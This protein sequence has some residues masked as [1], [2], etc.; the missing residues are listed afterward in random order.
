MF[1]M[2]ITFAQKVVYVRVD[3]TGTGTSWANASSLEQAMTLATSGDQ[4]WVQQGL[5]YPSATVQVPT[6]VQM[7]GGFLGNETLLSQRNYAENRTIIDGQ[8]RRVVRL[9]NNAVLDGFA[10]ING[11]AHIDF[12]GPRGG[13]VWMENNARVEN[14]YILDNTASEYGGGIHAV[15]DGLVYN[16]LF[17]GNIAGIDGLAIY[18][19]TLEVRNVTISQNSRLGDLATV[20][21]FYCNIATPA[22]IIVGR[23][24]FATDSIWLTDTLL[25][26]DAVTV[27]TCNK[28]FYNGGEVGPPS[29]FH[30][31]CRSNPDF[32]GDLFSWCAV[33][34]FGDELCPAPW[35]VPT[36]QDFID[37]DMTMG[38]NGGNNQNIG[39]A[40]VTARYL[41]TWGGAYGGYC[42]SGGTLDGQGLHAI[43]WSQSQFNTISGLRLHFSFY[44]YAS[45]QMLH[46][47]DFGFTLRCVYTCPRIILNLTSGE[48]TRTQAVCQNSPITPVTHSWSGGAATATLAWDVIPEGITGNA[49][50]F[51][52][53]PT[54]PGVYKWTIT[55][56]HS[57]SMCPPKI[58]TGSIIVKP[59]PTAIT[60]EQTGT[61][62]TCDSTILTAS[63]GN[64]GTIYWQNT[65]YNGTDTTNPSTSQIVY[66]TGT[67][68][69]R[70]RS[71]EGCWGGSMCRS[72]TIHTAPL[73]IR[74][75]DT[76]EQ[77]VLEGQSNFPVLSVSATS[78]LPP[79]LYQWYRNTTNSNIGGTL[80]PGATSAT[81]TPPNTPAGTFYY[82]CRVSNSCGSVTSNVSGKH[83]VEPL[84]IDANGC[85]NLPPGWGES[86]GV[87]SFAT[88]SIWVLG[89]QAWSDAIQTTVCNNKTN[90]NG[91]N[92]WPINFNADCRSSHNSSSLFS[93]CAVKR[94]SH[95]LCPAPWRVP[96]RQDFINLNETFGGSS[97]I[98]S[99]PLSKYINEWGG[100]FMGTCSGIGELSHLNRFGNYWSQT[101]NPGTQGASRLM[102]DNWNNGVDLHNSTTKDGGLAL[103]CVRD[104]TPPLPQ[105]VGIKVYQYVLP[106]NT[107]WNVSEGFR[108][109][110]VFR[111][112]NSQAGSPGALR[113][114]VLETIYLSLPHWNYSSVEVFASHVAFTGSVPYRLL[115]APQS[116]N[117]ENYTGSNIMNY[118]QNA[119]WFNRPFREFQN[120]SQF[121][122][123]LNLLAVNEDKINLWFFL[124]PYNNTTNSTMYLVNSPIIRLRINGVE[125]PTF[126][127]D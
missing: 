7:Y 87:V 95:V 103:R 70:A 1:A 35:R 126:R 111:F 39:N 79:P 66:H 29:T 114:N 85:N 76:T 20:D 117:P 72:V 19:T 92:I 47:K 90:F 115:T 73:I 93:W 14:C 59:S 88:D 23:Q 49:A 123:P 52:G 68:C 9:G 54:T 84:I 61:I 97:T 121:T 64:D 113:L 31:D 58:D 36:V 56:T 55:A 17:S 30:A 57:D 120:A 33:K 34:R 112:E 83:T 106:E 89:N 105:Q 94:F 116:F 28:P 24:S 2:F 99:A 125:I 25:W 91:G 48:N 15:G 46:S 67:Y 71:D 65:N 107:H 86:L 82:Y 4:V 51:S 41:N 69:F 50:S 43:Y 109:P 21:T 37:L 16:T 78:T 53:T 18:G 102:L 110:H 119:L 38:G 45:P 13:G 26:S 42:N 77:R 118:V 101:A 108:D 32:K 104:T 81:Y 62:P 5:Y 27:N 124:T 127:I 96:I 75:P 12:L 44:G 100:V 60:I 10:I 40:A 6:G 74:H 80:I 22:W 122:V 11:H 98:I 8:K 63:N 3:G